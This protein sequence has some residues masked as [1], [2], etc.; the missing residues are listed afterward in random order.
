MNLGGQRSGVGFPVCSVFIL[1]LLFLGIQASPGVDH[2]LSN[3]PPLSQ[4]HPSPYPTASISM[5]LLSRRTARSQT[6]RTVS[7]SGVTSAAR[8]ELY[9]H[10]PASPSPSPASPRRSPGWPSAPRTPSSQVPGLAP[11]PSGTSRLALPSFLRVSLCF[12]SS[13]IKLLLE[14]NRI[15]WM[16]PECIFIPA[17]LLPSSVSV[18]WARPRAPQT[19]PVSLT[20]PNVY[21]PKRDSVL[22]F[23]ITTFAIL[24]IP[25]TRH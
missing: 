6:S 22:T 2:F 8:F 5:K 9:G 15:S 18:H 24:S 3:Q 1:R 20:D 12:F 7:T 4:D 23:S 17:Q 13:R 11:V 19:P 25:G 21:P 16:P 10:P 14:S